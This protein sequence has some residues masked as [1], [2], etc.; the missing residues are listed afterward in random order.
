[1]CRYVCCCSNT[2]EE[3]QRH[4]QNRI[5]VGISFASLAYMAMY[6]IVHSRLVHMVEVK[7]LVAEEQG[8]FRKGRGC[9]V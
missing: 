2:K 3:E 6:S 1:M 5:S 7:Q 9:S 4:V 8:G